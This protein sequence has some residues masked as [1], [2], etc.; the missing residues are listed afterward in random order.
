MDEKG[1]SLALKIQQAVISVIIPALNEAEHISR[2]LHAVQRQKQPHEIIV[3]DG[4]SK[5]DTR[6]I[7]SAFSNVQLLSSEKGR[8]HQMN[9]GAK[10][11]KGEILLFLHADTILPENGL[12]KINR[13]MEDPRRVA[14]SFY[15]KFDSDHWILSF[16]TQLSRINNSFFTYGDHAIFVRRSCF[17]E[18]G[19]YSPIPF[20][21]DVEIQSRLRSRGRFVKLRE[22]VLTSARRFNQYGVIK[23]FFADIGLILLYKLGVS[24]GK[25][26]KYYRD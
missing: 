15:L 13:A 11:A 4:G 14:G 12:E 3:V 20:M 5:D 10:L 16:Y 8:S 23:Q 18:I 17:E 24:P 6:G 9:C 2:T 22:G 1:H 21:E 7:V 25:L 19:G 26:K